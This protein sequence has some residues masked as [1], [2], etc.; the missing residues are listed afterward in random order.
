MFSASLWSF[1]ARE[2]ENLIS[3]ANFRG[4]KILEPIS[5]FTPN[6]RAPKISSRLLSSKEFSRFERMP[7][8]PAIPPFTK[9]CL[10]SF[11]FSKTGISMLRREAMSFFV[12]VPLT[13]EILLIGNFKPRENSHVFGKRYIP[14]ASQGYIPSEIWRYGN[15]AVIS[16]KKTCFDP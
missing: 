16:D 11:A 12:E 6:F 13:D 7:N 1:S 9:K 5:A 8:S 14:G 3:T 10:F 2:I 15:F 4:R